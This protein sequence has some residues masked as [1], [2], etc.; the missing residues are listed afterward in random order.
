MKEVILRQ[1]NKPRDTLE[2]DIEWICDSFG[3]KSGRDT[4]ST[5]N[6]IVLD[7]LNQKSENERVTSETIAN[8]LELTQNLIN[9]HLRRLIKSG[10]IIRENKEILIRGGSIKEA[11]RE[12]RNDTLRMLDAIEKIAEDIDDELNI[13]N[14]Q[15][16]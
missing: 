16:K 11:V 8:N 1:Y 9:H 4:E 13:K 2:E 12:I 6:K 14:R 3:L 10:L 7:I 5:C 15:I